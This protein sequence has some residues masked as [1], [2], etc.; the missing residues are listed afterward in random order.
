M[1]SMHLFIAWKQDR[2][3]KKNVRCQKCLEFRYWI[4]DST[5]KII[6]L[7]KLYATKRAELSKAL[8]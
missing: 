4:Y 6:H 5:G 7:Y 8:K 3:N 2:T 1:I